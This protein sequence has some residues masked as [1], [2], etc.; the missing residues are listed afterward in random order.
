M[1]HVVQ[2]RVA[3]IGRRVRRLLLLYG[4]SWVV[5]A[6]VGSAVVSMALDT[7][8]RFNDHG[9]RLIG[10]VAVA[11]CGLWAVWRY[12]LPALRQPLDDVLVAQRIENHFAGM[13]D[14]LSTLDRI[15]AADAT[16]RGIYASL[17]CR[18]PAL[19]RTATHDQVPTCPSRRS[20]SARQPVFAL[21]GWSSA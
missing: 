10:S 5:G 1:H 3:A 9:V 14:Q 21:T 17:K 7:L 18:R 20:S 8:L 13:G 2:Q 6:L 15:L 12:L 19:S 4:L 11:G 16:L